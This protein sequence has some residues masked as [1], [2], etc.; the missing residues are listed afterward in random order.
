LVAGGVCTSSVLGAFFA[1]CLLGHASL[2]AAAPVPATHDAVS[3]VSQQTVGMPA[4][5][6]T[7]KTLQPDNQ[8]ESLQLRKN[9]KLA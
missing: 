5:I 7:V 6:H 4:F 9:F 1:G 3:K 8:K 2:A